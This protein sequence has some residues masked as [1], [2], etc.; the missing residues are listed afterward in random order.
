M[1]P[2]PR[3]ARAAREGDFFVR[4]RRRGERRILCGR[5]ISGERISGFD[6]SVD[7]VV[8]VSWLPPVSPRKI[9][10][11]GLNDREHALEMGKPLPRE[12]LLFLKAVTSLAAHGSPVVYPQVSSR[13]DYE[14]EIALVVGRTA[15]HIAPREAKRHIFG[16]CAA[17]DV[18]ARDI[19]ASDVQYTRAKSFPGFCPVGPAIEVGGTPEGRTVI[20]RVNGEIRQEGR[21]SS[22]I[23]GWEDLVSYISHM[24]PLEPG[25]I[26]LTGTYRGVGAVKIGDRMTVEV[27]GIPIPLSNTLVSDPHPGLFSLW[28]QAMGS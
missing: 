2:L 20:T 7:P 16:I 6:G 4:Y 26:V 18:T 3:E 9:V 23:F 14:G 27:S 10:A 1:S 22:Q 11:V 19:Q 25:D 12:P 17:N 8:D 28:P 24:M 21:V 15:D 13:V 5:L